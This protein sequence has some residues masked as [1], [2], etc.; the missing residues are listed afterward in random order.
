MCLAI[1]S[2]WNQNF[3]FRFALSFSL[4]YRIEITLNWKQWSM[5]LRCVK[6][7]Q[8]WVHKMKLD[9]PPTGQPASSLG[10]LMTTSTT[11][12]GSILSGTLLIVGVACGVSLVLINI[13]IIGCCLRK[14]STKQI[15]RGKFMDILSG[16]SPMC[17]ERMS[18]IWCWALRIVYR[19]WTNYR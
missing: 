15:K 3:V 16:A 5:K 6:F 2:N 10:G 13:L 19:V 8:N 9:A 1:Q 18:S 7:N 4:D 14:R 11:P 12:V 17:A